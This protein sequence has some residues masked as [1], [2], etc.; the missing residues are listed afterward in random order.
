[1]R[2]MSTARTSFDPGSTVLDAFD[3]DPASVERVGQGLINGTWLVRSI[4]N[5]ALV[6]QRVNPIFPGPVNRDIDIVTRHLSSK[7]LTTPRLT[8]TRS[9]ALWLDNEGAVW[10]VL[11]RIDGQTYNIVE[12]PERAT[13]AGR[14]LAEF[15]YAVT[16]LDCEFQN[17]RLGV[18]DTAAHVAGLQA[19]LS[20]HRDHS[21]FSRI[22]ALADEVQEQA[23]ALQALPKVPDRIV[24]GDPKIENIMFARDD[25]RAL[26]LIDLDTLT[27]MPV[28][29]ELGDALRSWCNPSTEDAAGA[30]FSVELFGAALS[31]YAHGMQ[32]LL[33]RNEWQAIVA[34]T[35]TISVELAARFC[36]D[37]LNESYFSW[38]PARY[39][40][41]S[42]H[43]QARTRAQLNVAKAI[44]RQRSELEAMVTRA[45]GD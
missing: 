23:A 37:A 31:A 20:N 24:H 12:S 21:E 34:A 10:R 25:E 39:S 11:T 16:D 14:V 15:H 43:N 8:P 36:T 30:G 40:S 32:Q 4:A 28:A 9:G 1:M 18:H 29:L 45:F 35:L 44:K 33:E 22:R 7:G 41:A 38:D 6:L 13:E 27:R 5:E 19:A 17:A 42:V 2:T 26:C 3:L